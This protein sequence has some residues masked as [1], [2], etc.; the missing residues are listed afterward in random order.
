M[1][2][3][4]KKQF[5]D[6]FFK[7]PTCNVF[8]KYDSSLC[9]YCGNLFSYD[10]E[11]GQ[12]YVSGRGCFKCGFS[13]ELDSP[14]CANCKNK[15]TIMCPQCGS[16]I[17]VVG[18]RCKKCGTSIGDLYIHKK[19]GQQLIPKQVSLI[20]KINLYFAAFMF[21][22]FALFFVFLAFRNEGADATTTVLLM[23]GAAIFGIL[24]VIV[25]MSIFMERKK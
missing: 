5:L 25:G 6:L 20:S 1:R 14:C 4:E 12:Y 9:E 10:D 24:L 23:A 22:G 18:A 16:E 13:N 21:L 2:K 17:E 11:T 8:L 3:Q 15:F 7:C 19:I